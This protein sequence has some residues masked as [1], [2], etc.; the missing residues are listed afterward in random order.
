[1]FALFVAHHVLNWQWYR[2]L[3]KGRYT[4][5][6]AF[7]TAINF[8]VLIA[9]IG[10]MV[11]SIMLSRYAFDFLQIRSGKAF[12][13][14]L[15]LL[16]SYWGFV[17]MSLHV[18]LHLGMIMGDGSQIAAKPASISRSGVIV[19]R[20]AAVLVAAYGVY[21]F[22]K[23]DI[24]SY[25]LFINTFAFFDYE[26]PLVLFFADY[27]A[28]MALFVFLAYYATK[29]DTERLVKKARVKG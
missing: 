9:M 10:L 4:T 28:V 5:L 20:A 23:H 1:M 12:A 29:T 11:S 17:L 22:W 21:A 7:Q 24:G 14:E 3:F 15:H 18:G 19:L 6:R 2:N 25:L 13:R 8:L 26:R 16:T 27:L